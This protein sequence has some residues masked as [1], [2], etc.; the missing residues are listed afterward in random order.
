MNRTSWLGWRRRSLPVPI[1]L[2]VESLTAPAGGGDRLA[3]ELH[4]HLADGRAHAVGGADV[5]WPA[6]EPSRV[7][8]ELA[9]AVGIATVALRRAP[10]GGRPRRRG[11]LGVRVV[12]PHRVGRARRPSPARRTRGARPAA[13]GWPRPWRRRPTGRPTPRSAPATGRSRG[14]RVFDVRCRSRP[15]TSTWRISSVERAVVRLAGS[16]RGSARRSAG[17]GSPRPARRRCRAG[18]PA[19]S[20]RPRPR[21]ARAP[22]THAT[23]SDDARAHAA[24]HPARDG[25]SRSI[26]GHGPRAL[27]LDL[28]GRD[29]GGQGWGRQDDGD[30][31]AGHRSGPHGHERADRRGRGQIGARRRA[32]ASRRS[33]TRKRSSDRGCGRAPSP[34]TTPCSSTSRTTVCDG[35]RSGSSVGRPRRGRH[36][37]ARA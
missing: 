4:D 8:R 17:R 25:D 13:G 11:V 33:P 34:P 6:V 14:R 24:A 7:A 37:G 2:A 12:E 35:S 36:R 10:R 23:T 30:R 9:G 31:H 3:V 28:P 20:P 16:R 27:L 26:G 1:T 22:T 5:A 32:S 19:A 29:R 21:R 18:R 15:P